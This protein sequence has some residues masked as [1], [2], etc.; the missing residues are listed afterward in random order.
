MAIPNIKQIWQKV[1][2]TG[3]KIEL[4][5]DITTAAA[6][7]VIALGVV[8]T[9]I[10]TAPVTT[11]TI[12]SIPLIGLGGKWLQSISNNRKSQ[13]EEW[14]ALAVPLAYISSFDNLV[15]KNY[16][17]EKRFNNAASGVEIQQE[18]TELGKLELDAKLA[19]QA[20]TDFTESHLGLILKRQLSSYL[21]K[22]GIDKY[23][24]EII[25]GWVGW[26]TLNCIAELIS[27]EIKSKSSLS[28]ILNQNLIA[29]QEKIKN[30]KYSKINSYI[31]DQI[32]PESS[33]TVIKERWQILGEKD[34]TIPDLYVPLQAELLDSNGKVIENANPKQSPVILEKWAKDLL[35]NPN[36]QQQNQV[37]FI[38]GGPG[39]GKSVFCR[40]FAEWVHQN[41]H[42]V[43]TPIL[44]RLRDISTFENDIKQT[45]RTAVNADFAE[46]DDGWLTDANTRFLFLLDGFDELRMQRSS[47]KGIEEFLK[48]IGDLQQSCDNN[49]QMGHRFL[50]TGRDSALQGIERFIPHNL[51]RVEICLMKEVFQKR[52]LQKWKRK[53]GE[54]KSLTFGKFLKSD[55]CPEQV[56]ILAQEPLLLYL[57]AAMHRDGEITDS[58]FTGVSSNQAKITIYQKTVD[59]VLTKQRSKE[60][61]KEIT[62][63]ETEAL[64]RILAEVGLCVIQTGG[65]YTLIKHINER[66]R[67]DEDAKEILEDAQRKLGD[68]PLR[69]ALA[70]FY[71][72]SASANG[73][74]EGAVEFVHK[75][76]SEF[77]FAQ[78]LKNSCKQ[79]I[80]GEEKK[81]RWRFKLAKKQLEEEIYDLFGYGGLTGEIVQYLIGLI[82]LDRREQ[83]TSEELLRLFTRLQDFYYDWCAGK[84]INAYR[85]NLIDEEYQENLPQNKMMQLHKYG[86]K[87]GLREVDIYT[88]LNVLILLFKLHNYAPDK[89]ELKDKISFHPC[90]LSDSDIDQ[91]LLHR[92]ISYSNMIEIGEFLK[93]VGQHLNRADLRGA[94]L[95]DANLSGANLSDANLRGADLSDANLSGANLSGANLSDANLFS[96]NLSGA[97]LFSANLN[98]ADL[99]DANLSG[100]NLNRA[101]LR[102]ADL[103]DA[104]L[105]GA[106]LS[107]AYLNRANLSDADLRGANL[108]DAY[109]IKTDLSGA[110]FRRAKNLLPDQVKLATDWEEAIL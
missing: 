92:I 11:A 96:A 52:W 30:T 76:F 75:S 3:E 83:L 58:M 86:K 93:I 2:D 62:A 109:L 42:P 53:F 74:K 19:K 71:L 32:S 20:L 95:S 48:Q 82:L 9:A 36:S 13:L 103:S 94:D 81:Q 25:T 8:P 21:E 39:R 106:N 50:I 110:N 41:L 78:R 65:E 84:F 104:D 105:R 17:L 18:I 97:N 47:T 5:T 27:Q 37:M 6:G 79:W 23:T 16:W 70:A 91:D 49:S 24:A 55:S 101:D 28:E 90:H 64:K 10:A 51:A 99:S 7:L 44:I 60:L 73:V 22:A 33:N 67:C 80:A 102:G 89:D 38:Q 107:G 40:V 46:G 66:L 68:N 29:A 98:R 12:A 45:L 31:Q 57:L 85:N 14:V 72:K 26:G 69:N 87:I 4:G 59:W 1:T 15:R 43:W 35:I 77:L 88:G 34:L 56:K 61:N 108:S 100:A 63:L 54:D